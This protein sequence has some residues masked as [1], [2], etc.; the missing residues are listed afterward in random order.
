MPAFKSIL[1]HQEIADV[2]TYVRNSWGNDDK[3][4]YGPDAG[5]LVTAADV[6]KV[7]K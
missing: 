7:D 2:V 3:D 5:G 1:S 6:A 4:K